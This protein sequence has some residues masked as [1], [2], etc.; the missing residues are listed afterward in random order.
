MA[1]VRVWVAKRDLERAPE[2][3]VAIDY[4]DALAGNDRMSPRLIQ[5]PSWM[6]PRSVEPSEVHCVIIK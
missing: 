2:F 6:R 3:R 4:A 5:F 1:K